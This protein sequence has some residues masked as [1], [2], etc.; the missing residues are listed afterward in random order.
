[1][2]ADLSNE[3]AVVIA[4]GG[5]TGPDAGR[6]AGPGRHR[7]RRRRAPRDAGPRRLAGGRPARPHDR[8]AR[9]AWRRRAVRRRGPGPSSRRL[10]LHPARHQ[11]LP[12][13][14]QLR[15]RALAA[16]HRARSSPSGSPSSAC[17]SSAAARS[18]GSRR[19]TTASTST[20]SDGTTLRAAVP[21]RLRRRAQPGAQ[22]RRHRLPRARPVDQLDH[23][24]GRDG[25]GAR[26]RPRRDGGGIGPS[27]GSGGGRA[28]PA[29]CSAR[30]TSSTP[31]TRPWTS[32]ATR[33]SP[34]YGTDFGLPPRRWIS[35]FTDVSRQAATY[36]AGRVLLA[37]D[38]AH[39]H[40]PQGGQ[41]LN[42]RRAGRG[43]PR[44][45]ARAGRRRHLARRAARH[46]PRRAASRRAPACCTTRRAGRA[47][48]ARRPARRAARD[49]AELLALDEP[50]AAHRRR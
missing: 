39:V 21:R 33:S 35:R 20:L 16:R 31:A 44:L 23:R 2:A 4:G 24:R 47:L 49:L 14:P 11:R 28:H 15:A 3:H 10:R 46:V 12:D 41:G 25:G 42:T 38:A 5:P 9:P 34:R 40:P 29:S 43:E 6:R 7:R 1:M 26:A 22:G 50:A 32:C 19:T 30:P 27:T 13:A 48:D 45:E 17:R 18:S 37:G 36:R 8:G